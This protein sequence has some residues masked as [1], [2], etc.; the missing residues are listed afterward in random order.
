V[1]GADIASTNH[2]R[3]AGV[4][5]LF[6]CSE[7]GVSA[8]SSEISAVLKSEPTRADFSDDADCLEEEARPLAFDALAFGVGGADVLAGRTSDDDAGAKPEIAKKLL[9]GESSDI[10]VHPDARVVLEVERATPSYALAG[11]DGAKAG[12]VHAERPAAR[13][14]TEQVEDVHS[15]SPVFSTA[16]STMVRVAPTEKAKNRLPM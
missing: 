12:A 15:P 2:E 16:S 14:R 11:R 1:V 8:A 6:Q 5:E 3:P 9:S 7:D 4:A 13:R 10:V